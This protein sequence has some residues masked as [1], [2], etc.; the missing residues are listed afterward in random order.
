ML[1]ALGNNYNLC[2][3][4]SY[5]CSNGTD[6]LSCIGNTPFHQGLLLQPIQDKHS[7]VIVN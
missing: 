1:K 5:K 6:N 2:F 4:I 7:K 3:F